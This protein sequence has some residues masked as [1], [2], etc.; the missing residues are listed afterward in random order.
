VNHLKSHSEACEE[1]QQKHI[2]YQEKEKTKKEQG[3]AKQLLLFDVQ[4][5]GLEHGILMT[6]GHNEFTDLS[7]K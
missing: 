5:N 7:W 3:P 1:Y 4:D 6:Q 2:E